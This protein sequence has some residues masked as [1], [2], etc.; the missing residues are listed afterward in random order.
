MQRILYTLSGDYYIFYLLLVS[1]VLYKLQE[2]F[3]KILIL[4]AEIK[5]RY[6]IRQRLSSIAIKS[7][8]SDFIKFTEA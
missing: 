8:Q 1:I 3:Y 6:I 2:I 4:F 5:R 7:K